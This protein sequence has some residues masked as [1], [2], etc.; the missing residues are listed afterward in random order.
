MI[1]LSG[2]KEVEHNNYRCL[3]MVTD[4]ILISLFFKFV[5]FAV[6]SFFVFLMKVLLLIKNKL[7]HNK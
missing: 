3:Y 7:R 2:R 4:Y 1:L 6:F 5:V